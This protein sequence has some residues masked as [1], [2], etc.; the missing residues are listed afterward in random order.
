MFIKQVNEEKMLRLKNLCLIF[1]N[2]F[3]KEIERTILV[4]SQHLTS[5]DYVGKPTK[6]HLLLK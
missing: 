2:F 5:A 4:F 1:F 6:F 3:F